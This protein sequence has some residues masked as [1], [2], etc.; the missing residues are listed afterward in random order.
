[1]LTAQ[2][3]LRTWQSLYREWSALERELHSPAAAASGR[4][5]AEMQAQARAL[6]LRCAAALDALD[7][8]IADMRRPAGDERSGA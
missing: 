6:Q 5:A 3:K 2:E 1:M 4:T 7:S 8:A